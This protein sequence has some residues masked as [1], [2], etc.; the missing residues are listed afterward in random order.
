MHSAVVFA[1]SLTHNAREEG[2]EHA[3]GIGERTV[4]I[5]N[6]IVAVFFDVVV[7]RVAVGA[8]TVVEA[9]AAA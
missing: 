5:E 4:V 6:I 9:S 3:L 8:A 2:N 7:C 1:L